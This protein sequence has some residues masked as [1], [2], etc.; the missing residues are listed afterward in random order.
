MN[1]KNHLPPET[2]NQTQES[3]K[4]K[5]QTTVA[6]TKFTVENDFVYRGTFATNE[7]TGERKAISGGKYL[8]NELSVR[9]AIAITFGFKSFAR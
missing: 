3:K 5:I 1:K 9:K 6:G 4:M 8:R 2:K 7:E